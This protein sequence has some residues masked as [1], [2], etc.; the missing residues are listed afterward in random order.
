LEA[1]AVD[2][3]L[4]DEELFDSL[5]QH[6][7]SGGLRDRFER[8]TAVRDYLSEVWNSSSISPEYFSWDAAC[9]VGEPTFARVQRYLARQAT[10]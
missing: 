8:A 5:A 2:I 7:R 1:I 9:A 3:P 10:A 4:F 6:Y